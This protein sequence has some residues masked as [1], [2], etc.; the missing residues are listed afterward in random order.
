MVFK[1]IDIHPHNLQ[2]RI[3]GFEKYAPS[4]QEYDS[5][6]EHLRLLSLGEITGKEVSEKRQ[7]KLLDMF[8]MFFKH[9]K[10]PTSK[11]T[12]EDL[13]NY[14]LNLLNDKIKKENGEPYGDKTK[15]DCTETIA[16]YLECN[17]PKKVS[18]WASKTQTFRKWFVIRA[19]KTTPETLEESEVK[20]LIEACET[21]DGKF[22]IAILFDSGCRIEEFL[23]IRFE[24]I[25]K[26]TS[27][28]PYY[29]IDFKEEY[30]K[31]NGRNIGMYCDFSSQ[32]FANY[33]EEIKKGDNKDLVYPKNY[34]AVRMF[35]KRLGQRVLNKRVHPHI[36]RKSS[37]TYYANKMNRQQLYVRL[38]WDF[39]SPMGDI[40]IRRAGV[41][42]AKVKDVMLNDDLSVLKKENKELETKL[43][44]IKEF[45]EKDKMLNDKKLKALA[46]T[47]ELLRK[48]MSQ[49]AQ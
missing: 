14:K 47:M 30:S 42:E 34:G 3:K 38:G 15:E 7:R 28:F 29:K 49:L 11:L 26:P 33:L 48:D 31:T 6:I 4:K 20:K 21:N 35:L 24:D 25:T 19:K 44:I 45:A 37:A 9:S 39:A 32:I 5:V 23:N 27:N 10:K 8:I 12:L 43:G 40:Y 16:R 1:K 41:D 22:L 46:R 17:S 18:S 36:F 2:S 13:R